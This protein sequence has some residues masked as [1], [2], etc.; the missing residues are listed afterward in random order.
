MEADSHVAHYPVFHLVSH[1]VFGLTEGIIE[2]WNSQLAELARE[3]RFMLSARIDASELELR[4]ILQTLSL[5][6]IEWTLHP[7]IDLRET[8][9]RFVSVMESRRAR[10][11]EIKE[12]AFEA[13]KAFQVS[14]FH[15]DIR[16]NPSVAHKRFENWI[17][18]SSLDP[19]KELTLFLDP[20][21]GEPAAFFLSRREGDSVFLELT[22]VFEKFR[23]K[24]LALSVWETFL[25]HQNAAQVRIVSTNISAENSAVIGL[26]PKLGFSFSNSSVAFHG[27]YGADAKP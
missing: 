1:K 20:R 11:D 27:H 24:G 6:V 16:I 17:L 7:F 19:R 15:R 9:R 8:S 5:Q 23:G 10:G 18:N 4:S 25:S 12:V 14:R 13:S 22:A 2:G 21:S 3:N 26:Y